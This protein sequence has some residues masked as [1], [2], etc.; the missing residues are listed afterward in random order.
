[1]ESGKNNFVLGLA[2]GVAVVSLGGM[3]FMY[4]KGNKEVTKE[5]NSNQAAQVADNKNNNQNNNEPQE[6][7]QK[8]DIKVSDSDHVRGNKD[9]KVTIV[10]FSD[11]Q[12]SFCS[13][14]HETM[15]EVAKNYPKDVKW[16]FKHFPLESIHPHARKAAEAS[17]CAAEQGKF[18]EYL[19]Y[20]FENQTQLNFDF[21]KTAAANLKLDTKK[22]NSCYDTG[23]YKAKVDADYKEGVK[24]GVNG[25]PGN[26]ING[27]S[28]PGAIP[29]S[30]FESM[31][32]S[33]LQ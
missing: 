23:K 30:Q 18:W 6:P 26:F 28:A 16:V 32:K 29:Y 2:I 4:T 15:R 7:P 25:T 22:F 1:M 20:M 9:A 21:I 3:A 5:D 12:C 17:E 14:H 8:V 31:I 33:N 10:E 24:Y 11:I 13:R 19:D 27:Q